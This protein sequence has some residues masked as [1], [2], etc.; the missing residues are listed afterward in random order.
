M[1]S[2]LQIIAI[3]TLLH[4]CQ[5][6]GQTLP[7]N[8]IGCAALPC[9]DDAAGDSQC[10]V[11]DKTFSNVGL[12]RIPVTSQTLT[13]ISWTEG[14]SV[15]DSNDTTSRTFEKAFYLGVPPKTNLTGTGACAVFFN[16]VSK[17][18]VFDNQD[19]EEAQGTCQEALNSQ[20]VS[21]LVDRAEKVDVVGLGSA[22]ACTKLDASFKETVDSACTVFA[23]GN[24]WSGLSVKPLTGTQ[25]ATPIT[26]SQNGTSNCWP[27]VPREY[28]LSLVASTKSSGDFLIETESMNFF[29]ITPILTLFYP[30][31]GTLITKAEA[32]MTCMKSVGPSASKNAT[33]NGSD[34]GSAGS[35][36]GPSVVA[37]ATILSLS[38]LAVL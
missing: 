18:V 29:G 16:Q 38:I 17:K 28:D 4:I 11:V 30:G 33:K 8:I 37:L 31:N 20:C 6:L 32:Q 21:A 14:V 26:E 9:P 2:I 1:H 13:G 25:A 5:T 24:I 35:V 22:D 27:I 15:I 12:S 10:T 19:V 36:Y 34:K 3:L 23:N 7:S